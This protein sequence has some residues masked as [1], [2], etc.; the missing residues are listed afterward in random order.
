M[1][2]LFVLDDWRHNG[3]AAAL[4]DACWKRWPDLSLGV[5]VTEAGEAFL[6]T[7]T[8]GQAGS[9]RRDGHLPLPTTVT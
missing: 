6:K 9:A 7:Y 2:Y 3:I 1:D 8:V 5:G 4:I